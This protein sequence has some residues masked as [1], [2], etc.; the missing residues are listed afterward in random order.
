VSGE[1]ELAIQQTPEVMAVA[2]VD[3][4]GPLPPGLDNITVFA[5]GVGAGSENV[6]AA[7]AVIELLHTPEAQAVFKARGLDPA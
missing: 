7:K 5:A 3:L 4:V 6:G 2:G 1:A